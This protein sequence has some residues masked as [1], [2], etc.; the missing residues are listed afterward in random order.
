[1]KRIATAV[2]L[3][4]FLAGGASAADEWGDLVGKF[5]YDGTPPTPAKINVDKDKEAF[6][7]LGLVDESLVVDEKTHGIANIVVYVRTKNVKVHPDIEKNL[8]KKVRYDNLG[9]KFV[10]R[11]LAIWYTKQSVELHN[12][13][14]VAHNSNVTPLGDQSINPLIP[15]GGAVEHTF[16]KAQIVGIPVGCTIHSWMRGYIIPRDNPYFAVT[17]KEGNFKIENLPVG[18]LDFRAWH[19][20][21]WVAVGKWEKGQFSMKIKPG[22]N[23]L[24]E[25]KVPASLYK[26]K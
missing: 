22:K 2:L 20:K 5:T 6:G 19:E 10:P 11:V 7:N 9:G 23:D 16:N 18:D 4:V 13:D 14:G 1:M 25:I 8:P 3:V 12:S 21:G 24:G 15:A 17:D 26:G